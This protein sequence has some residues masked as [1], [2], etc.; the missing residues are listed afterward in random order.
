MSLINK[1]T[2]KLLRIPFS[3]FLMPVFL[4][5]ISQINDINWTRSIW[6]FLIIHLLVYPS[7]NGYNSYVDRDETS[8]GGLEKPPMPTQNLFYTTIVMDILACLLSLFFVNI[9]FSICILIYIL[10]SRAY[11]SPQIRLKKYAFGGFATVVIFQGAF[12]YFMTN[13]AGSNVPL[14]FNSETIFIL[15]ATSFQIAG[16]YP[17]T[18]VYQ[19]EADRKDGVNTISMVLGYNGTFVFSSIMLALCNIFYGIY[20]FNTNQINS[21]WGLQILFFIPIVYFVQWFWQVNQNQEAANF[22]NTMRMN[23]LSSVAMNIFSISLIIFNH[24]A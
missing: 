9:T 5:A 20:F 19:H 14:T 16:A 21:F 12:T 11:S 3:V 18:Q 17:L 1:N 13:I 7:S 23:F 8:I 22:K 10:A 2:I 4:L 24:F 15:L 6:A